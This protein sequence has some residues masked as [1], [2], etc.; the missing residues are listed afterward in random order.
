MQCAW[1]DNDEIKTLACVCVCICASASKPCFVVVHFVSTHAVVV[2]VYKIQNLYISIRLCQSPN[3]KYKAVGLSVHCMAKKRKENWHR[4][5]VF[6]NSTAFASVHS[7][8]LK[9][10]EIIIDFPEWARAPAHLRSCTLF[11]SPI[12]HHFR[13]ISIRSVY[14]VFDRRE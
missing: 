3:S 10:I 8:A 5:F 9:H 1:P 7:I 6:T 14:M 11:R 13:I 4:Q 12:N 2:F